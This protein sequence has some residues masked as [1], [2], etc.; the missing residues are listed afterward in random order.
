MLMKNKKSQ[1]APLAR[2]VKEFHKAA[3]RWEGLLVDIAVIFVFVGIKIAE[4][5]LI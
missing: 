5:Y 4:R 2:V 1:I 3:P